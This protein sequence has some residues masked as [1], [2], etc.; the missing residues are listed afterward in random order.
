MASN[1]GADMPG[2]TILLGEQG[3]TGAGSSGEADET[4]A[5]DTVGEMVVKEFFAMVS[6]AAKDGG[7]VPIC[8]GVVPILADTGRQWQTLADTVS[9]IGVT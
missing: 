1:A 5:G 4:M 7:F 6:M 3:A 8:G 2:E 9:D